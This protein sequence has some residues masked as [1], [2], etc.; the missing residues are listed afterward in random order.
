M[1]TPWYWS[2]YIVFVCIII[3]LML[4][5]QLYVYVTRLKNKKKKP[6]QQKKSKFGEGTDVAAK[7]ST[8]KGEDIELG[9]EIAGQQMD[10][11]S[12][13]ISRVIYSLMN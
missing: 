8:S 7:K 5:S 11:T 13:I 2:P 9:E 1:S 10:L 12:G 3:G 4:I 6:V